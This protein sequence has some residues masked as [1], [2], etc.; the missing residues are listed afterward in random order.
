MLRVHWVL[1]FTDK[2][3]VGAQVP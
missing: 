2:W 3:S 1:R